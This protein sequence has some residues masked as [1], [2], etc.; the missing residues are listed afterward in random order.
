MYIAELGN[1]MYFKNNY[2]NAIDFLKRNYVVT[3]MKDIS[4][5]KELYPFNYIYVK[6]EINNCLYNYISQYS[7]DKVINCDKIEKYFKS[8]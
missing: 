3:F 2:N 6:N 8:F 7:S 5:K 1:Y 4:E